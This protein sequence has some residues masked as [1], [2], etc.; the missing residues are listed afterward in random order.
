MQ[1]SEDYY[2][3]GKAVSQKLSKI[4]VDSSVQNRGQNFY[5]ISIQNGKEYSLH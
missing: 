4:N 2:T 1:Q 5:M 3:L